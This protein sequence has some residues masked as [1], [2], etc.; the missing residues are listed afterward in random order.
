MTAIASRLL[1]GLSVALLTRAAGAQ[2]IVGI[3]TDSASRQPIPGAVVQ[4]LDAAG[5]MHGRALTNARGQYLLRP[6]A[7]VSQLRT[8]R[9]GFRP[10]TQALP[11]S[12]DG[13]IRV[14]VSMQAFPSFLEAVR[15]VSAQC[16]RRTGRD[17]P[18]GLIEQARAGL[19]ATVVAA[20]QNP[21]AMTR[22][23]Y[24]R[25]MRGNSRNVAEQRIRRD[26]SAQAVKSFTAVADAEGFVRRG[27]LEEGDGVQTYF[28]PDAEVLLDDRFAAGY[29]FRL[30]PRERARPR[31]VGLGFEPANTRP[32][33]VDIAGTL[34]IDTAAR[35]LR[36]IEFR[37][38]GLQ[39][40]VQNLRPG[41]RISFRAMP[42][43]IVIVDRW[44]LDLAGI[45]WDT[46]GTPQANRVSIVYRPF[47]YESGG[48]L[49]R[50]RWPD[51]TVFDAELGEL[52]GRA[53]WESGGPARGLRLA[54]AGTPY[55]ADT[56][57][58]GAFTMPDLLPGTYQVNA[59][60]ER[61]VG[62]AYV[63]RTSAEFEIA[64]EPL[65]VRV[66]VPTAEQIVVAG[67]RALERFN[68]AVDKTYVLARAL[69]PDGTPLEDVTWSIEMLA[70]DGW[71]E[72]AK[73]GRTG[74]DGLIPHCQDLVRGADVVVVARAAD[75]TVRR[76]R[77]TLEAQVTVIPM[78]FP[79][80]P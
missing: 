80:A 35:E 31:Q 38:L 74:S 4:A 60:D 29:C 15:V 33:R 44:H 30:V 42:N 71:E 75:G 62:I 54:L 28:A 41:G 19:L 8:I 26:S 56:D 46:V 5:V 21:A 3:V 65:M 20:E 61:L 59:V 6:S 76:E 73:E 45:S 55:R 1:L 11:A 27:F 24:E 36:D 14:D 43:G 34:W 39:R 9:I 69:R 77:R 47:R 32:G 68:P 18:I 51:S 16:R 58:A 57:S 40:P 13:S 37:Y 70:G 17:S 7:P 10:H 50:A 78:L 66:Q 67:C 49:A 79:A 22:L 53:V 52:R 72:V 25:R 12:V 63:T 2:T 23:T 64:R 48:E